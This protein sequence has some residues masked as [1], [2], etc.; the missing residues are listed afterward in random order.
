MTLPLEGITVLDMSRYLPGG[1]CTMVLADM[2]AEVI[3]VEEPWS[4]RE[5]ALSGPGAVPNKERAQAFSSV[6]RNKKSIGLN[7]KSTEAREV[8]YKLVE[9]ADVIVESNRPLVAQRLGVDYETVSKI[10]PRIIYCSI[11]GYGQDGPYSGFSG[12]DINYISM[13]GALYLIGEADRQPV[14]P[15]N[16]LADYGGG[17]ANGVI[18]ILS[19]LIARNKTGKGQYI[20]ISLTDSVISLLCSFTVN[21]LYNKVVP[22]RQAAWPSGGYPY[23]NIYQTKDGGFITIG[24]LEPWLWENFCR[25]IG[26]EEFI[27]VQF[28]IDHFVYPPEGSRWQEVSSYLKEVFL[29]KT[30]DEWFE[31]LSQRDVPVGKV[32]SMDEVFA[33]PQVLHRQMVIEVEHP[34]EGK[35]KQ[36]GM[37]IKLSDTPGKVRSLSPVL[38]EHTEEVLTGLGYNKERIDKLRQKG[39]IG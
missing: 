7:L 33:D 26:K 25:A 5:A 30:R 32:Y 12:H 38:G 36:V 39:V 19:A 11:T 8:F 6:E 34:T 4:E 35:V 13:G 14:I 20:D 37:A 22:Q 1:Y 18:G 31:F 10:N 16:L 29:T 28:E 3:K 2:G 17:G 24:C 27:P 23:Y 9:K 15:L 21:Y